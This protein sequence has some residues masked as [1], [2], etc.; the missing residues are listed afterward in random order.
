MGHGSR[1]GP[2]SLGRGIV[3]LPDSQIPDEY[4]AAPNYRIDE[5]AL[6]QPVHLVEALHGHWLKRERVVIELAVDKSA[7]KKPEFLETAVYDLEPT[8]EFSQ[9]RLHFL[10]WA[11]NYDATSGDPIWWHS[12]LARRLGL[13]EHPE[14]EVDIN[15]PIWCDGGPRL[16]I[17]FPVLHRE[18]I[19]ERSIK[20]TL[21]PQ[22]NSTELA[23]DQRRAVAHVGGSARILAPAGSGK[24]RVLTSRILELRQRGIETTCL[25]AV[26]YNRRAAREMQDRLAEPNLSVRTL[27][28]LGY[29][30]VRRYLGAQVASSRQVRSILRSLLR[31]TPQLNSDPYQ[32]YIDALQSV[33]LG[34]RNPKDVESETDDIPGFAEFFPRYRN[35]LAQQN[36]VDHDE[37]IYG[38]IEVLLRQ[39][40]ARKEVQRQCT[41]LCVDEF[42]DLTPAFL[43]LIRLLSAP[44]YQVFGVGDDDQVI[45]G[46]AGATPKYL[47]N[48]EDYF[49]GA[50]K[51]SLNINYRCPA[52]IVDC[53]TQLLSCNKVRVEK[54]TKARQKGDQAPKHWVV[55]QEQWTSETLKQ[56]QNWLK[57]HSPE[58]IA[59]LSRVNSLLMPVQVALTQL[60]IPHQK[61]VDSA[62]LERT[63]VRTALAYWRL[64]RHPNDLASADLQDALRR[65]N[66]KLKREYIDQISKCSDRV[67]L[68][69][70]ALKLDSWPSSQLDEFLADL[71]FLERRLKKGHASF[72]SALR[73]ETEFLGA[74]QQLDEGGLG[75][76]GSSHG[77]DLLALEQ[78]SHLCEEENF[79]EW[80][81]DWLEKPADPRP[82]IRLSSI[83]R[84]KG[85]E[86]PCVLV[87]GVDQ[88]LFPHRL[89]DDLEEERRILH[90]ALTRTQKHC[91]LV[92]SGKTP[93]PFIAEMKLEKTKPKFRKV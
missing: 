92:G 40:K 47:V 72:F 45:Y 39:P 41:H 63:G 78:L 21:G 90:V 8:F 23:E 43:L 74:L 82:G 42:Q 68:K 86:W 84:V 65:P 4:Q 13:N 71:T 56:V 81:R 36:W 46:Y 17:P 33:R 11:N 7:L 16:S 61:V 52:A 24:T 93:S 53:A 50:K 14:A 49:P 2:E 37:Q 67:S 48:Y 54:K 70:C 26:A 3:I 59:I 31:V 83:H 32:P 19:R 22:L 29:G 1:F 44:S 55:A 80:L 12:L 66:R 73:G 18:S 35:R 5:R 20:L 30:I 60:E 91:T 87:F 79:E 77:D 76:A 27:H 9:E 64:C 34:L 57:E 10:L 25:T 62:I 69:R 58:E 51:Y 15:G 38:A 6:A 88:G 28:S 75:S 89:S 85:L